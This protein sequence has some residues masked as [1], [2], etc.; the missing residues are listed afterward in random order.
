MSNRFVLFIFSVWL[1]A[2]LERWHNIVFRDFCYSYDVAEGIIRA[3]YFGTGRGFVNLGS[4]VETTIRDLVETLHEVVPFNYVFDDTKPS[5]FPRRVMDISYAKELID[6]DPQT[7]LLEGLT[8][9][10]EWFM[11]H[12][13]EYL[14]RKNYFNE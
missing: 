12:K 1:H 10:W 3:L 11:E 13:E 6:Y 7:N 9:T 5:G 8:E 14:N 2:K 4:G